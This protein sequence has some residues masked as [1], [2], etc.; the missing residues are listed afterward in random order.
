TY[1]PA[2]AG[3]ASRPQYRSRQPPPRY[4]RGSDRLAADISGR[5]AGRGMARYGLWTGVVYVPIGTAQPR[6]DWH[7]LLAALDCVCDRLRQRA[8]SPNHVPLP[9]LS[10][11][12]RLRA[13]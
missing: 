8:L 5:A 1:L 10:D 11:A 4:D 2:F 9:K 13:V 3:S 7:R 12:R 6:R